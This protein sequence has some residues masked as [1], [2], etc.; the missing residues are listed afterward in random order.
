MVEFSETEVTLQP[1]EAA[2]FSATFT[3]PSNLDPVMLPI[4]G[5]GIVIASDKGEVSRIPYMG[6]IAESDHHEQKAD[7][8]QVSRDRCTQPTFG[9]WNVEC[10]S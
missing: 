6:K 3:E 10:P 1:G 5:G 9:K 4:Y 8:F 2:T 7:S